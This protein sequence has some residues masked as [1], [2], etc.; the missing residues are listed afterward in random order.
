M[1]G[2]LNN[3]SKGAAARTLVD[4]CLQ[5]SRLKHVDAVPAVLVER[6]AVLVGARRVMLVLDDAGAPHI[7][8]SQLPQG[9]SAAALLAAITPWLDSARRSRRARLRHGPA[10][11]PL[12]EQR[13]C[14]VV[15]VLADERCLGLLYADLEGRFGRLHGT[16]RL[17]LSQLAQLSASALV[18]LQQVQEALSREAASADI[19]RVISASPSDVQ[20]VFDAIVTSAVKLIACERVVL[21]RC[22]DTAFWCEAS[23]DR[24]GLRTIRDKGRIPIDPR[25]NF[26]S[27]VITDLAT[28]HL[29]DW[30][31]ID[32]PEHE[33]RVRDTTGVE[34]SLMMP[35]VCEGRC[36]GVLS[37]WRRRAGAFS[38]Q[39]IAL[40]ESFRDQAMI[41]IQNARL[42]NETKEAL[43]HQTATAEILRVISESPND[44]QP[45]FHAIVAA[46]ARLVRSDGA[47]LFMREGDYYRV[48]SIVRTGRPIF[49]PGKHLTPIDGNANFPSRVMLSGQML[50]IPD[51]LAVELPSHERQVHAQTGIRSAVML[52]ILRGA[53]CIGA[54]GVR[55]EAPGEFSADDIGLLRGFVDQAVIAI[56]N[57]RLFNET[58]E[59]LAHQTASAE[60]LRVISRSP[61]DV[62]PV[63]DII[64]ER[65]M[66]LCGARFGW[67]FTFDG[68]WIR[69]ASFSGLGSNAAQAFGG[70]FPMQPG[71]NAVV[72]RTVSEGA[73]VNVADVLADPLYAVKRTA[74][75]AGFRSALGVPMKRDGRIVGAITVAREAVGEYP[76][77]QVAMLETFA[78]Q[79]VIAI[80]NTRLF[81]ETQQT[82]AHQTASAD[83]LRVISSSPTDVQPVF[84]A[85]VSTAVKHLGC[86]IAIVQI[87]SGD[88]Y[89]PAAMA[90][91]AGLTP[92]PGAQVMPVDP[93][94]NF[95]SRA[96][97]SKAPLHVRD[98]TAVELPPHEQVRHQQL[99]LNSA[100]YLPLLRGDDCVGVLVLGSKRANAFNHQA[101]ALAESFRDQAVIAIENTR[102]FN[103]TKEALERQTAT[104]EI[105]KVIA[106]SPSDVQPVLDAIVES[107][108]QLIGGFS[109]TVMRVLDGAVHLA[110][111]TATDEAGA[112]AL[113]ARFPTPLGEGY[114]LEP[115]RTGRPVQIDDIETHH[116]LTS[117][118]RD[119]ARQRRYRA[120]V[121][122]PMLREGAPIG[123]ISVTRTEPG[124]F[125]AHQVE[126]LHTFADQAVIAI[127]NTR[128]F[129]ETQEALERQ[130]ATADILEVISRSP[131][132]TQPVFDAVVQAA[133]RLFGRKA[134][135]RT[136]EHDGLRRRARSYD[137][138]DEFHGAELLPIDAR[139]LVGRAVLEGRALQEPDTHAA[140]ATPY[141][142]EHA[143]ELAFRSIAS[144]PLLRE[145]HAIGVISVSSPEPGA[146]SE[147]QM[148][149]LATFANQAVI[150]M[151]NTRLFNET[152]EALE[153]QTATAEV[154]QVISGSMADAAPVFEKI[155]DS[156]ER[157]FATGDL[158][159]FLVEG[160]TMPPPVACRGHFSR[161]SST[162]YPR[163]LAGTITGMVLDSGEMLH[164]ADTLTTPFIPDYMRQVALDNGNFA[165]ATVPLMW[166]GQG[167]GTLNVMRRPP[168]PFTDKEL[169]LLRTFGDQAVIAIQNARLFNDTK[170]ALER[171]TATADILKVISASP[172]NV[173]P[174]LDAVA[175]RASVLCHADGGRV[176]LVA[177]GVLRAM[178]NYGPAYAERSSDETLP[179]D[180]TSIG[181]RAAVEGRPV[182]VEDARQAAE[183]QYPGIRELQARYGFRTV[184]AVPLIREGASI[185]V[186]TLLRHEVCAFA[187]GEIEL[188][189]TF[190]DQAV[191]AIENV[192]LFNETK[193]A[194]EQ[195]KASSEVLQVIAGSMSDAQPV[196][197]KI[198]ESCSRLFRGT[199][200]ALN[201]LD[202]DDVLHLVAQRIADG[203][204][205][206]FSA[207]Q[208]RAIHELSHTA[209][210]IRVRGKEL[211]WMRRAK[212]VYSVGDVLNDPRVGPALRAPS[213]ALGFS[214]AQMGATMFSGDKCIGSIVV[215]REAGL[216]FSDKEQAQL[217]MFA[218]QAVVA[219]QN[220]RLFNETK[221]ALEQQKASADILRVISSSVADT[222]PVFDKILDSCKILFGGDELD[223]LLVDEQDRLYVAAYVGKARETIEATFPAPVVGSAPGL[224][225]TERRAIQYA[226]VLHAPD[227]PPVMRRMGE[228]VGYHSIAF[229]P[230]LWEGRGIGVVGVARSRGA[231]SDKELALL[232]TFA[233]QAVIAIQNARLFHETQEALARQTATSDVLQVISESPTDVQPVFDIIAE[234]AASLTAARFCLV[235]RLDGEKLQLV[236]LHGVNDAG[237][238]ALR[239]AW[240]QPVASSTSIA[241]RA[242]RTRSVVNVADLLALPDDEYAPVFK[243]A[244]E[245]AGFRSGLAVPMVRDQQVVGAITVNRAE[246][247][248][249]ADKEV[250]LLQT[251]ARQALVAIENVR[252]FNET[253]EALERQTATSEVLQVINESPGNLQPVFEAIADKV[254]RLCEVDTGGLWLVEGQVAHAGGGTRGNWPKSWMDWAL[255]RDIPLEQLLGRE[256]LKRPYVH[257][258]DLKETRGYKTGGPLAVASVDLGGVRTNLLVPLIDDGAVVGILSASRRT[259][260][261]FS[262]RHISLVQAFAAQA[263]IA[264]KNARLMNETREA[265]ERQTATAEVLQVIGSSVADTAPV[266]DK[267]LDSC[268]HLFATDQL[269][270][271]QVS[272]AGMIDV[273]AWRGEA[274]GAVARTFP[275]P[276]EQSASAQV[277]RDKRILHIPDA[278]AAA[279]APPTV[280]SV[281]AQ[282]GNFSIAWAPMLWEGRGIG[283]LCALRQP[284]KPFTDKELAL[285]QTFSDQAVIA[286]QNARLFRE[287]NEALERQTATAEVLQ[288][289]SGSVADA[290]PVF[291]KIM[292]SC[293]RLISCVGGAVLVIDDQQRVEVGAVH[294]DHDGMFTH[295]Y[296]RPIERTVLGL[297]FDSRRP[298]YYPAARAG[299]GVPDLVRRFAHKAGFDSLL[300]APMFWE[301]RR[302]GCISIARQAPS[303]FSPKDIDLLQTFADQGVI[304]IQ[305]ARLFNE[306]KEALEQQR[307]SGEVLKVISHSVADTAPV[308]EAIGKACQQ[309][310]SGDQAVISLVGADGQV[311]H[312]S[313]ATGPEVD[314]QQRDVSWALLNRGFPRPLERAYQAYP[315]RKRRVVHYPD[316]LN[317]PGVPEGMR[318]VPRAIG[319]FSM[320][321]A[322]M[323]WEDQ[324]IGTVHVVRQPP[325]P[326]SD[327]EHSLL[328]SFADQAVI[329][330]Q[331]ARLF[332]EAQEAR[333]QAEAANEAKSAFLA[334]MSHEIRTPMNAVIGMSGLLLDT[335]LTDEQRDY[336][337]TIRDSGDALLT[338]IN[339]ILDFSKIEAGRMDIEAHPFD[340]RECVESALDLVGSRAAEKHLD[341]AYLFE[342]E[343]PPA[344][345]GD[346][347]RLR[348]ILLNLLAN[349]VKFT[350]AGE[351]V[352]A[353]SARAA[354]G[355]VELGF[356]VRDTGIGLSTQGLSKLFRSF[357]QAD[358]STTRKYGGTGLGLAISKRLAELMGGRMWAESAGPG[359]G[360]TFHFTVVTPLAEQPLVN[361][362]DFTGQQPALAGQRVL[363][364]D[365]NA[366]NRKVLALQTGKWGMLPQDTA[367]PAQVL[368]WLDA[369][370]R[371]DVAI[372][373]MHMPEMDGLALARQVRERVPKLPLVLFSSLGRREA[374]DTDGLFS[375][376]LSKP[377]H[378]SQL[379]DTLVGLLARDEARGPA[380]PRAKTSMDAGMAARHPLRIL[381]AE[382]NV[383][384]QKLA[385][386]LLSQMGYRADL[387]SNGVEAI[388]CVERQTYDV[389]LMDVQMP[390]M[391]GLEA[392]RRITTRWPQGRRPRIVAMTA[393]AMQG[394]REA[395]L[396]AGMDDYLTKPIRVDALV[397]ALGQ[398][399]QRTDAASAQHD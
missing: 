235:T 388:E 330:I 120:M 180:A 161:W 328:A 340:L 124:A 24:G 44:L 177:D 282:I 112:A 269:G 197:E 302:I 137:A 57:A 191:I 5:L 105:L 156:C 153:R 214:Y 271:F 152:K 364:V 315:I 30:S 62:Q 325:R 75:L 289:I 13:S 45:V 64:A 280:R 10:C 76:P 386:R 399:A 299:E 224:A 115:L 228:L 333:A 237:T 397:A 109:A 4:A 344:V 128:L 117:E 108:R 233:D 360:S 257:V 318:E 72:A 163:A 266:F 77:H 218:D 3:E 136:V 119:L 244:C 314:P 70:V 358:S 48:M 243:R 396:S 186:L 54:M 138:G 19:L 86:D 216:G 349:A 165:G 389:V 240:P 129:N 66:R 347:T 385:L 52:P 291:D 78:D 69:V 173:Q 39:E 239:D 390:E 87:C 85:I 155:L 260:R 276:I 267:I 51:W 296:P 143:R 182:H 259:V 363:V 201:L 40:A 148:G 230:M 375:A 227:I 43:D 84:E 327:K 351:V 79:A 133:A 83:I 398:V 342:G 338:I 377:L 332:K 303:A 255:G 135:L 192:R 18:R 98:W 37:M 262:E 304:A 126:L 184:L 286:I 41:A 204:L 55:R 300:I 369:G 309:L 278:G 225:I 229:A 379:F 111:Y 60:I 2:V 194:L 220:A 61:T 160:Q 357:S 346:V 106:R 22:D 336:A 16:D 293:K 167:I 212:A 277:L 374:G 159:I 7:A 394:D 343:V 270:I 294:G 170:Q 205:H 199:T 241:A 298:L 236:S 81:N 187:E 367:S 251:F 189:R 366:T 65:A 21:A 274:L 179:L 323:L 307:T 196:F 264:M 140:A 1:A 93:A 198:L 281:L 217:M 73:V 15:P 285:L 354:E 211:A 68:E 334:T 261:A 246:T 337:G 188:V 175:E 123:M 322:P 245:A 176:W 210:P 200:Q 96:I 164:W 252:L 350:E 9:E 326:F 213:L 172:T 297:A 392:S 101:I 373:D 162:T 279:D 256:P 263:Q 121:N 193:E 312:A 157:L 142:R 12:R 208:I 53:E 127:E 92:V 32:L 316:L 91:P 42:F 185:G 383:V 353:V 158:A 335:P 195:Q 166:Q 144:A 265:L 100:L 313:M 169:A 391:D 395:C 28:L 94:A 122:V 14:L 154:L 118:W 283:T 382:D 145:G 258:L 219:I 190:A 181:G 341:L 125:P 345:S 139:S 287:T 59:A 206:G 223:V 74:E 226:D 209:Y 134:A 46:A 361:R 321:I 97:A 376:Y 95:P 58:Q 275:K 149:L 250:A 8:A 132:D 103:E 305:N 11:A 339:D 352:L 80:E 301:V 20:P 26:P 89:S 359:Q 288:V 23:A 249:Y 131:T 308:F 168:R 114:P 222:Q 102:L 47:F 107:A 355:G 151:E 27:R 50:H 71:G 67:V 207:E 380:Q 35:L 183:S 82:L 215:N 33:R 370:E 371:F 365:D 88:N 284:P 6:A 231:F 99:G 248:L 171:Q 310:F 273:A 31:A 348:Q 253:K 116:E 113:K 174:V 38:D 268:Q 147:K 292:D 221:E 232:Q 306:T 331:N 56:Q 372:L 49:G 384:N 329:A 90:T 317:G 378:Q 110:A 242:I 311:S 247:G 238:A 202:D 319:N 130:T 141:A 368:Q 381:V 272:D 17:A 29:P 295:G 150:A 234:Q 356:A 178:T 146:L 324:G 203:A 63:F 393:N 290:K 254:G 25:A 320:L 36:I 362:R 34:A 104:A 387:A